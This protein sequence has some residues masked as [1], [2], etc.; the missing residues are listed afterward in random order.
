MMKI[1]YTYYISAGVFHMYKFSIYGREKIKL[2]HA[3][4]AY[5]DGEYSREL[6]RLRKK[7]NIREHSGEQT[8]KTYDAFILSIYLSSKNTKISKNGYDLH[9]IHYALVKWKWDEKQRHISSTLDEFKEDL[10]KSAQPIPGKEEEFEMQIRMIRTR[11][12]LTFN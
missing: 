4:L 3:G 12:N 1:F 5:T 2:V 7:Y 6:Q 10:L 11:F 9:P 8:A